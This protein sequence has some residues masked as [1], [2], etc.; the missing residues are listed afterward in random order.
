MLDYIRIGCAVPAVRVGDTRKNA[1][2]ICEFLRKADAQNVDLLVFPEMS[3]TGYTCQDLFF[4]DT[5]NEGVWAGLR[6]ILETSAVCPR[7]TAVVGLP[8]RLGARMFNCAAVVARGRIQGIVPK[9]AIPNYN[10]FYEK[11][12]FASGD[13]LDVDSLDVGTRLGGAPEF[14]PLGQ[15]LLFRLADGALVGVEIC[16]DLW[17]PL[18]P[19][20]ML[21]L[22]G[23]EVIVNLSASNET[24]GKRS[25]LSLIHI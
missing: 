11:R 19:S 21:A 23:A 3:L 7:L 2:D 14:V 12:W 15:N 22:A 16:E 18:P 4:Q 20:A 1:E 25:Y 24:I 17:A 5:L 8:L 6:E 10:E 13:A 9:T